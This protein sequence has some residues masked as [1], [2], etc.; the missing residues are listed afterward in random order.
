MTAPAPVLPRPASA[1][2]AA[3]L[4]QV[5]RVYGGGATEVRALDGVSLD[6]PAHR[7]TAVVGP[8]GSGKSTLLHTAAALDAPTSGTIHLGDTEISGLTETR[9]TLLRRDRIGF[10]F[11]AY[12]L[13]ESLT[14]HQNL[15]LPARLAGRE[16]DSDHL[17]QLAERVGLG[18]RLHHLPSQLSGGQQQRAAIVR[19]LVGSPDVVFADEPTGALDLASARE[20]L[21]LLRELVDD[22]GQTVVLVTHDP[23]AAAR[24]HH[25]VVMAGGAITT[26]IDHPTPQ[27]VATEL[28]RGGLR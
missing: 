26:V 20:V 8:S 19:A 14:V 4:R 25:A 21:D 10:V 28:L 24:A 7:F 16:V 5:T 12:N 1:Q 9:R 13:V 17:A 11:Q 23:A 22:L 18:D 15:T 2:A 6:I 3:R 27:S